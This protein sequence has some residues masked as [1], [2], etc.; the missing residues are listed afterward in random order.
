MILQD[1]YGVI[2]VKNYQSGR[3]R[4]Q[5]DVLI[6]NDELEQEFYWE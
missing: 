5:T 3:L 1:F 6:E 2:Q 4:L